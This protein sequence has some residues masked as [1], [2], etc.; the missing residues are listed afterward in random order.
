ME[1]VDIVAKR[2]CQ[3]ED[4]GMPRSDR[5]Y[6]SPRWRKLTKDIQRRDLWQCGYC[7]RPSWCA[8]HR[9]RP[10]LGGD[11]W[12]LANLVAACRSCNVKRRYNPDW[13]PAPP[14]PRPFQPSR[15]RLV[16]ADYSKKPKIG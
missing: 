8:D 4:P 5:R 14:K 12:D 6:G 11:F 7:G 9:L 10:D 1:S 15:W 16:V 13:T 3:L 2:R